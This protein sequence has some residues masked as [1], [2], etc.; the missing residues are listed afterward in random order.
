MTYGASPNATFSPGSVSGPIPSASPVGP[1]TDPCGPAPAHASLSARQAK[2]AGLMTSGTYGPRSYGSYASAAL[3]R[4]LASRLQARTDLGGPTLYSL[5]WKERITPAGLSIPAL[6]GTARRTSGSGSGSQPTIFDLP[7][8]GW[9]T[10][11]V[12][13]S[14]HAEATQWEVDNRP[15]DDLL[16]TAAALSGWMTPRARGDAGGS[17][18]T[19]NDIRNLED[20]IRYNLSGWPT[21]MA[22]TP[23]QNGNN[24]AGNTDSSR[25]T[26][27]LAG[28][29]TPQATQGPNNS[30]NRG[31]GS[32]RRLTPQ[33]VRDLLAGGTTPARLT[34][35]GE[36]LIGCSAGMESGGPLNPAHSRWLIGLPPEWD[37]CA[38]TATRSMRK[39]RKPS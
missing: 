24:E 5:I 8:V 29:P 38:P 27:A 19:T 25:K 14:K 10:P 3:R 23:A 17:R 21:P 4:C 15:A 9:P 28:W 20:Q 35:S 32:R 30:E 2:A 12:Q 16:H 18:W 11:R 39:P 6:R 22:G 37:A 33:N 34:A 36:M 7:Q 1:M 13:D 26:M 31:D